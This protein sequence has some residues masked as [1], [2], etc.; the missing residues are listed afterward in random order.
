VTTLDPGAIEV[1]TQGFTSSPFSTALRATRADPTIT[2]GFEVLVHEVMAAMT[3]LPSVRENSSP[4]TSIFTIR[5]PP[6]GASRRAECVAPPVATAGSGEPPPV[7]PTFRERPPSPDQL[8][9]VRS[10][11]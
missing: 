7:A 4:S 2:E 8:S 11:V 10:S 6:S 1:F 3:M 5:G 9:A